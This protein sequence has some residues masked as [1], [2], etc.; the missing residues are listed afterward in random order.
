MNKRFVFVYAIIFVGFFVLL[1]R[2]FDIMVIKHDKFVKKSEN[3]RL[4]E[5]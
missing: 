3:Q 2:L 5:V 1:G 4:A